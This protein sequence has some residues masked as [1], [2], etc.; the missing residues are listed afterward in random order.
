MVFNLLDSAVLM[1][2]AGL[3]DPNTHVFTN[4]P[5]MIAGG[6]GGQIAG[7]RHIRYADGTSTPRLFVTL[8]EKMDAPT[9]LLTDDA[10]KLERLSG[11]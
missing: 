4:Q 3:S 7:G 2:G 10:R 8:M 9:E 1:Y 6:A 11:L 5:V